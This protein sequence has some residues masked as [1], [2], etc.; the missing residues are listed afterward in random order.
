VIWD[1]RDDR[2]RK[3]SSGV[4]FCRFKTKEVEKAKKL[5]LLR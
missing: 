5:I 1:G 2:G 4:Y 3:V